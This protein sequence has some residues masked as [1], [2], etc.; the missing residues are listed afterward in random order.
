VLLIED[1]TLIDGTGAAARPSMSVLIEDGRIMRIASSAAIN[2]PDGVQRIDGRGKWLLP[3]LIDMHVHVAL[4]GEESLPLWLGAGITT[5]RDVGGDIAALLPL[6]DAIAH[7]ERLGPRVMSYGPMLDGDPPIF[8]GGFSNLTW[9]NRTVDEGIQAIDRLLAAGVDGIK[10]YAGLRPEF[11]R[12]MIRRVDGRVP[13]TGHLS[14]TWASEAVDAGI[15]CLEH[16]HATVYQD[17]APPSFRHERERGNGYIPTYWTWLSHGWAA[18]DLDAPYVRTFVEKL[19]AHDICLSPTTV[20]AT[21]GM[22]TSDALADPALPV[23]TTPT[24]R[25]RREQQAQRMAEVRARLEAEG[26]TPAAPE[27]LAPGEGERALAH[28][29]AFLRMVHEAGGTVTPS[30]DVG[31]APN[32][33]P[34]FSLHQELALFVRAGFSPLETLHAATG[35]AARVLRRPDIGVVAPGKIADLI[36]LDADPLADIA[37]TRSVSTVIRAGKSYDAQALLAG[38]REEFANPR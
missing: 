24:M 2:A 29:L 5:V 10:L 17:V 1:V 15:N 19:V 21:G 31:A 3:G 25:Q 20:L 27:T 14:R 11:V 8:A 30:T 9:I 13:V 22:A 32:Q 6:R 12:A 37:N 23:Y 7:G 4:V 38:V 34:G 18:A 28:E 26:R 33:V 16:V 35:K 36:L